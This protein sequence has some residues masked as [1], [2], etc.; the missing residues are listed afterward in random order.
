MPP[1]TSLG[2]LQR[3]P[4]PI[5]SLSPSPD[6]TLPGE[7]HQALGDNVEVHPAADAEAARHAVE[8]HDV[9]AVL[10][11]DGPDQLRLEIAGAVGTSTTSVVN[12]LVGAYAHGAG[13]HVTTED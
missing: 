2:R 12:N 7:I 3:A 10:S 8:R 5:R 1:A 11:T 6:P 4:S 13:K 9:V